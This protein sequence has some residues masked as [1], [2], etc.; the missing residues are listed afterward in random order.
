MPAGYLWRTPLRLIQVMQDHTPCRILA[1]F[2]ASGGAAPVRVLSC[3]VDFSSMSRIA[4]LPKWSIP[5]VYIVIAMVAAMALPRM[6]ARYLH[7]FATSISTNAAF[8]FFSA[9]SS[10]MM[11]LTGIVFA[12]AFVIVQFSA[13]A[14]SPRLSV[15]MDNSG[16]LFHTLG[17]FSATFLY[18]LAALI[19][20]DRGGDGRVPFFSTMVV[21]GLVFISMLAF[22]KLI[23]SVTDLQIHNVLRHVGVRGRSII[24]KMFPLLSDV[25]ALAI[26]V[27]DE[28][29]GPETQRLVYSG[30]PLVIERFDIAAMVRLAESLDAVLVVEC[31]VGDTLVEDTLLLRVHGAARVVS[32]TALLE[33]VK[34][35]VVRTFEQDPRYPIRLLVDIAIRA[36][37]PAIND[38]TTAVQAIDQIEDLLRRLGRRQIDVSSVRDA[39]GRLRL[40]HPTPE[41]QDYLALS[42]DEIRQ[43]GATSVQVMRRLRSALV[44]LSETV[45]TEARRSEVRRYLAHL[46]S[47]MGRSSLDDQDK[48]AALEE[49]RQGLGQSRKRPSAA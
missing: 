11:A 34:L 13:M 22:A 25:E 31:A 43:F 20:T 46:N 37:S 40:I 38:P 27:A 14:Y 45:G 41:W 28:D 24:G 8:A 9:V 36:L 23:Q 1:E 21:V 33:T 7:D 4:R 48:V 49:D 26:A 2:G 30:E 47:G 35:A 29:L 32:D 10:G 16:S 17:L 5:I 18:S 44:G 19:W 6:E 15:L 42:F 12:V 39:Q 3:I